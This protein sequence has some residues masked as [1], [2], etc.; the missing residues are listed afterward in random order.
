MTELIKV[1]VHDYIATVMMDRPPVNAQNTAFREE[2]I[3]AFDSF[4]DRDDVRVA[5]LTG[6]G[7]MFSAGADM[8]ARPTGDTPGEYW[9]FNRYV[10]EMFNSI[11]E[12]AKPV[13][14]AVNGP[15]LGA[16]FGLV[17]A[18]DIIMASDNAVFGMPEIDIG[19]MGGAAML[20][21]FFGRSR[22]RRMF[23]TG[24]RVPADELYRTGV[25][26]CSVPL[27]QLMP[28]AM[29][30]A[31]EIASKSPLAMR[32]AKQSMNVTMHMPPRDGYR[33]EQGMTVAL[34]KS[35]D[36]R[37]ARDAF[38]EKRKPNWTGH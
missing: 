32:Y 10:R 12:C 35:D 13:I 2:L 16:G 22:S 36:A 5:V 7:K 15:A 23:F 31:A 38:F 6:F 8:K 4:T 33:F 25:I 11:H 27:E 17:A 3:A 26:E 29:K 1:T 21:Q 37:E 9:A 30:L 19:L 18:C 28:S 14:A 34:S 20:Q 24:W